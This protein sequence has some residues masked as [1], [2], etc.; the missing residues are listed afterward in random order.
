MTAVDFKIKGSTISVVVL[1][2]SRYSPD[3]F[4]IQLDKQI[5]QAPQF[6]IDAPVLI[7]LNKLDEQDLVIDFTT[8][9]QQCLDLG[10]QPVAFKGVSES[11]LAAVKATNLAILA[12]A[13]TPAVARALNV[14]EANRA[15]A[16]SVTEDLG[17][18]PKAEVVIKTVI[19][20]KLVQN[21]AK[22][23]TKPV[24]SGQQVYAQG[25]DLV[26]LA[27]VSE[28]AEVLADGNIHIYGAL[29]G[30]ALAGVLG[31]SKARIF[32]QNMEAELISI[33]GN[34]LPSDAI[35]EKTRNQA[36]QVLLEADSL[37]I[38][39]L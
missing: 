19:Q 27:H 4:S 34:F 20:E 22:L 35:E 25:G 16:D 8:L 18:E 15:Q 33:A 17:P 6:F 38:K 31:D 1:E 3:D 23:V 9:I 21:P 32:C 39:S 7:D 36:V 28:G 5:Q 10:L 24:R 2:L 14:P 30:R 37:K 11:L 13:S 12:D 26:V 29:R